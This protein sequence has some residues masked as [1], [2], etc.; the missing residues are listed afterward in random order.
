MFLTSAQ[1]EKVLARILT[2]NISEAEVPDWARSV[3]LAL[4]DQNSERL[5]AADHSARSSTQISRFGR[6]ALSFNQQLGS[7]VDETQMLATATEEMSATASEIERL[8]QHVLTKAGYSQ[9]NT[10][11]G[12]K[13]LAALLDHLGSVESTIS[14]VGE[15]VRGFVEKT[16]VILSL[17]DT[18]NAIADQTNLLA[19]NAAI[20]AA[21]AGEHGRGFAVVADEVRGLA[22]RSAEA[23]SEIQG[24]V[25]EVVDGASKIDSTV[26][27]AVGVLQESIQNRQDVETALDE[28]HISAGE[29]VEAATQIASAASQQKSV[30]H[31]MAQRVA[32][33]AD[34]ALALSEVFSETSQILK[35]LRENQAAILANLEFENPNMTLTLAK[36]DHVVWV[37][38]VVRYALYG[39]NSISP[40]ELKDHT[41]CR[42]GRFLESPAGQA[43]KNEKLFDDL[44]KHIHPQVHK[45]GIALYELANRKEPDKDKHLKSEADNLIQLSGQVLD[46]LDTFIKK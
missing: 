8:G 1:V 38:K 31:D 16:Q 26:Q 18:V 10:V 9:G 46:I 22:S 2:N 33:S 42:L 21:R 29:N 7:L 24:I 25:S 23:A 3:F 30:T 36:N 41:Q 28:A 43:Y 11:E 5:H 32:E 15:Y 37:D 19:L 14:H 44:Y 13:Q 45:T 17:T 40:Q 35:S 4:Q 20:E 6:I 12:K 39:E 34:S 27:V